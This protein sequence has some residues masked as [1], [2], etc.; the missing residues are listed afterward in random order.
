MRLKQ[1]SDYYKQVQ[2]QM[3]ITRRKWCDFVVWTP[4]WL[5][6]EHIKFNPVYWD[7][8]FLKLDH[9]FINWLGPYV[10]SRGC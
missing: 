2:G 3:A 7:A 4:N 1:S 9:F 10:I 6:V 5:T 8:M